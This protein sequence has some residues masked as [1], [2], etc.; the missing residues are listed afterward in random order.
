MMQGVNKSKRL[1]HPRHTSRQGSV[2]VMCALAMVVVIG[3]AA[4]AVDI[5]LYTLSANRLQRAADS[6]ALAGAGNLVFTQGNFSLNAT[7]AGGN[8][9]Y[10]SSSNVTVSSASQNAARS[11]A[12]LVAGLNGASISSNDVTFPT[13]YRVRVVTRENSRMFFARV[14]GVGSAYLERRATAEMTGVTGIGGAAPLGLSTSD[15]IRYGPGGTNAGGDFTVGLVVNQSDPFGA[16]NAIAL[17]LDNNPSKSVSAFEN[18]L[19]DGYSGV[20]NIQDQVNSLN[21][22]T[23]VQNAAYDALAARVAA[24]DTTFPVMIV[25]PKDQTNGSSYFIGNLA[26]VEIIS[27]RAPRPGNNGRPT[28]ITL[29]FLTSSQI[30]LSNYTA[31]LTSSNSTTTDLYVLRL[32]DDL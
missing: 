6:A 8:W 14:F 21:G 12:M 11:T 2:L 25:P 32:V 5:G 29:R 22:Q 24:G 18:E 23:S 10:N 27:V 30:D 19:E 28:E 26:M 9:S 20:K 15:Y 3:A 7:N 31:N 13:I 17:S 4:I 16:G 1:T